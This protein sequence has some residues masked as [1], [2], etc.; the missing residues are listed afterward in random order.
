M[1]HESNVKQPVGFFLRLLRLD[2]QLPVLLEHQFLVLLAS[3]SATQPEAPVAVEPIANSAQK[4]HVFLHVGMEEYLVGLLDFSQQVDPSVALSQVNALLVV[5]LQKLLYFYYLR[6][7]LVA[8]FELLLNHKRII[9]SD[10]QHYDAILIEHKDGRVVEVLYVSYQHF[11][12]ENAHKLFVVELVYMQI[13]PKSYEFVIYQRVVRD[14]AYFVVL[15]AYVVDLSLIEDKVI[16]VFLG[17][18]ECYRLLNC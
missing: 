4:D 16:V 8:E 6:F 15:E 11:L 1:C 5:V 12:A 10:F 17:F 3:L 2:Q 7:V 9:D 14:C 13:V 18:E